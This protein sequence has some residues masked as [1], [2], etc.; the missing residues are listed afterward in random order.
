MVWSPGA[1]DFFLPEYGGAGGLFDRRCGDGGADDAVAS[2]AAGAEYP[3][4]PGGAAGGGPA[5][6]SCAPLA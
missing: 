6:A 4:P 2:A 3:R 5:P 1:F